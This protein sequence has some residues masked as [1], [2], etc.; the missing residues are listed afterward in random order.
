RD[1]L[2]LEDEELAMRE[3]SLF[4][5]AGGKTIVDVTNWGLGRDPHALTRISRATG[6]NIVMGS[7]YYTMDS[8]C[9]DTLKTKAEDE[10][11]ED[12]VGDIAVG[13]D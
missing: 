2:V 10:I 8:G 9:A 12:I 6:L 11:F 1:N 5:R 13:T 3:A 4:R 7:G